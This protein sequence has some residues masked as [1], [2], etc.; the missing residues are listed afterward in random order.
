LHKNN[1]A[2]AVRHE[3]VEL[4]EQISSKVREGKPRNRDP[5]ARLASAANE[6]LP[7]AKGNSEQNQVENVNSASQN[8]I[9]KSSSLTYVL[10]CIK[11]W[12]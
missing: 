3:M 5:E 10:H 11:M 7:A 6:N 4:G 9:K 12:V 2:V 8:H 1:D